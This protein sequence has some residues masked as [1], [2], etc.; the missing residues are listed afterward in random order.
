MSRFL[1]LI[2]SFI[3]FFSVSCAGVNKSTSRDNNKE[4]TM[5]TTSLDTATFGAGCFWCVE[6]IF[7]ELAG[8]EKVLPGYSGG[9]KDNPT[10][11][12]V[13]GGATGHA[14]VCQIYF[15]PKVISFEELLEIFWTTHNPTMLNR[16]GNDIGTQYRSVVFYHNEEQKEAAIK[17]KAEVATKIWEDPIVTEITEFD[18]FFQA[19]D[20]HNDYFAN[21]PN[22]GYCRVIIEPKVMKFRKQFKDKLKAK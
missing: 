18:K 7:T 17:S 4:N 19:E 2:S 9:H 1:Y 5:D 20:Y 8:V 21:N 10:Y 15:D 3:L 16:Q 6:A 12:E 13:C 14:E 11:R 22:Q